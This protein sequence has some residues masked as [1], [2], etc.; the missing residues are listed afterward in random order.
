VDAAGLEA[1]AGDHGARGVVCVDRA[2]A[3]ADR[4]DA[5][6]RGAPHDVVELAHP[7][8]GRADAELAADRGRVAPEGGAELD[9][10]EIAPAEDALRGRA[11]AEAG[12]FPGDDVDRAGGDAAAIGQQ[13][14]VDH[15]GQ[16]EL[17]HPL[18]QRGVERR[19]RAIGEPRGA[20]DMG[21]FRRRLHQLEVMD[22]VRGLGDAGG[23]EHAT[24]REVVVRVEVVGG[25][26]DADARPE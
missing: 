26:L 18:A 4:R 25:H 8:G 3:V 20:A 9:A 1:C 24:H 2:H 15:A 7:G 19:H 11:V 13:V 21:E 23:A 17:R 6:I 12:S 14:A 5:G 10:A 16:R 22:E